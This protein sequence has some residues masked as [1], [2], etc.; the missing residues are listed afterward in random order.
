MLM[1]KSIQK[2]AHQPLPL[3]TW[4]ARLFPVAAAPASAVAAPVAALPS[5]R[6][7]H[8]PHLPRQADS[9]HPSVSAPAAVTGPMTPLAW[10]ATLPPNLLPV[11]F[12]D[13][14]S[15]QLFRIS[16]M[17]RKQVAELLR[18]PLYTDQTTRWTSLGKELRRDDF[19]PA[20]AF[21]AQEAA[22]L[23]MED[24]V[25]ARW[26][27]TTELA[28]LD[29]EIGLTYAALLAPLMVQACA[30]D[31][32]PAAALAHSVELARFAQQLRT[33]KTMT[34]ELAQIDEAAIP[35]LQRLGMPLPDE[36]AMAAA[37]LKREET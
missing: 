20:T 8:T 23:A 37:E 22:L 5:E 2:W 19:T 10:F 33:R 29:G 6:A 4:L 35:A 27:A 14:A 3:V 11:L 36:L 13:E 15:G 9:A 21:Q 30:D 34:A 25:S 12:I 18:A 16:A 31:V 32:E 28:R 24:L 7:G 26:H 17:Q 1:L